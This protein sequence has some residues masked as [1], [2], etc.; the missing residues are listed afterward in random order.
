MPDKKKDTKST[1][2]RFKPASEKFE[3]REY[4]FYWVM[5]LG[6]RYTQEMEKQL[7][8]VG[9]N[10]TS[11]RVGLILKENGVISMTEVAKHA[12]GRL[13]TINK[14]V[15]R[16]QDQGLVEVHQNTKDGRVTMVGITKEGSQMIEQVIA[17][18]TRTI[19]RAFEGMNQV[20]IQ[21]MNDLLKQVFDNLSD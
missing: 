17:K 14:T 3:F 10:I 16:M 19:N 1:L 13:P 9:M 18:T 11:W 20:E 2:G 12:V 7:K 8:Q 6:N 5:R 21:Q 4:P 15:Y